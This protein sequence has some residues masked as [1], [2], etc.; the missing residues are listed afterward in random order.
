MTRVLLVLP[1]GTYKAPDFMAAARAVGAEVVVASDRR[2]ALSGML[3][4]RAVTLRL[5]DPDDAVERIVRLAERA[6]LDAVVAADDAGVLVAAHACERLGLRGNPPAAAARTRDKA[7]MRAALGAAGIPQPAYVI[8]DPGADV[9]AL[10]AEVGPPCVVKP[11][12]LS[13]S[14]GVIRADDPAAAARAAERVRAILAEAGCDPEDERLLVERYVPGAEIAVEALVRDGQLEPLAIF[15]K[16]D[17]LE[18]PFFE[19][20]LL[21]TPSRLEDGFRREVER[22]AAAAA[23]T[24]ELRAG[25]VHAELRVTPE[26]RVLVLELAAR[27]IGGL[28]ARALRFGLGSSLE[29]LVLRDALGLPLAGLRR[30]EAAAGVMMLPISRAG[31]LEEVR[32]AERARAVPGIAGLELSIAP[33]RPVRTLPEGDRYLGFLFARGARPAQVERALRAAHAELEVRIAETPGEVA[34]ARDAA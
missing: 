5:H 27:T 14:R 31:V 11:L 2:Q 15:D 17:P 30:E 3:T 12:A 34:P 10:A 25:P 33:G 6:Q 8:A 24:L 19:E 16:P 9:A 13:A 32:G 21:V 28:C 22:T 26:G 7:S 1:S 20:T 18:G 29:E 4:E 23:A